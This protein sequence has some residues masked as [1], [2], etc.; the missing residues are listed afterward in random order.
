MNT[1]R[2]VMRAYYDSLGSALQLRTILDP[3]LVF[4]GPIAGRRVGAEG[5]IKGVSGFVETMQE[6]HML[7][8]LTDGDLGAT[9]YDADMPG[10]TVRFAEFFE[11]REGRIRS[12]RLLY[13]AGEYRAR[14]GR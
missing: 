2:A 12:L 5:F 1:T 3:D 13:D 11:I 8:Q 4:E 9:L 6:L 7:H 14:G 10:G